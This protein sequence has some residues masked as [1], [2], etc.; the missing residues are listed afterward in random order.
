MGF[1]QSLDVQKYAD[2]LH[3]KM[4]EIL[5]PNEWAVYKGLFIDNKEEALLYEKNSQL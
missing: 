4:K 2:N 5:K 1:D 3:E